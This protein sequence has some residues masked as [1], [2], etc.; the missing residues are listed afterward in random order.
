M[1]FLEV[2]PQKLLCECDCYLQEKNFR[3][4]RSSGTQRRAGHRQDPLGKFWLA[5]GNTGVFMSSCVA[6]GKET[7]I[8][9]SLCSD[10]LPGLFLIPCE[11]S[12][13]LQSLFYCVLSSQLFLEWFILSIRLSSADEMPWSTHSFLLVLREKKRNSRARPRDERVWPELLFAFML[14]TALGPCPLGRVQ[15][16]TH[17]ASELHLPSHSSWECSLN[18]IL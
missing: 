17:S 6:C 12:P 18:E 15:S 1:V 7:S 8:Q 10:P 4:E 5:V 14:R 2:G 3:G 16:G 13:S 11:P 9:C